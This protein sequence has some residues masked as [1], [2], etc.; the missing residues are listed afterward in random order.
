MTQRKIP[1][2]I[3]A[4]D[5]NGGFG[6]DGKIPWDL[7]ED[8]KHFQTLTKGHVCVMG[9]VT[10][11]NILDMRVARDARKGINAMINEILPGRES[12]VVTSD[13]DYSTPGATR[14]DSFGIVQDRMYNDPRKLFV[15]GGYRLFIEALSWTN[16]I[17]MTILKSEKDY[18]CDVAFPVEVLNKKYTIASGNETESAYYITYQRR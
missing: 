1:E 16:T 3:V 12:F 11:N 18:K 2:I 15:I 13:R 5:R 17:H 9:R 14:I 7:P 8:L 6:K 4:V 10:Y